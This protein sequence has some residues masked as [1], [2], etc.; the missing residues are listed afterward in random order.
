MYALEQLSPQII[1]RRV[2][3]GISWSREVATNFSHRS[4]EFAPGS[5]SMGT[6]GGSSRTALDLKDE[7][8][9]KILEASPNP[10]PTH[11]KKSV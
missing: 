1:I 7:D 11:S 10:R 8:G 3:T 5:M 9:K 2:S 4:M 6:F